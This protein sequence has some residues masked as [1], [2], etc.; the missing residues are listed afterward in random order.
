MMV[1]DIGGLM[2]LSSGMRLFMF[3]WDLIM[4]SICYFILP[5]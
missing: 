2:A 5:D 3:V 1:D 4:A